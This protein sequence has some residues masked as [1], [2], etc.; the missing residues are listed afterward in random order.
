MRQVAGR[1]NRNGAER[2]EATSRKTATNEA[3]T[4]ALKKIQIGR[5][6][7]LGSSSFRSTRWRAYC[8]ARATTITD[9]EGRRCV[10]YA[11][12]RGGVVLESAPMREFVVRYVRRRR[13]AGAGYVRRAQVA[14]RSRARA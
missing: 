9:A 3:D 12:A 1:T 5:E 2:T 14:R 7:L 8:T 4:T 13:A 6:R 10:G 11:R